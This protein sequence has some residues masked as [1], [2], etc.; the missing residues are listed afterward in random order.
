MIKFETVTYLKHI[1]CDD[2]GSGSIVKC[3]IPDNITNIAVACKIA[4]NKNIEL[5]FPNNLTEID[6][7]GFAHC[8][9][10]EKVIFGN[11][12][13]LQISD[14]AFC[15]CKNIKSIEFG[16]GLEYI[17][18]D[19][20]WQC[21]N[22]KSITFREECIPEF[23]YHCFAECESLE[24]FIF[25]KIVKSINN[26]IFYG[27]SKLT[28]V[29]LPEKINESDEMHIPGYMFGECTSL[30]HIVIPEGY[31]WMDEGAFYR[32]ENLKSII[33][34]KSLIECADDTFEGCKSLNRLRLPPEFKFY[35]N[36]SDYF[37]GCSTSLVLEVAKDSD[38]MKYAIA[39]N[40]AYEVYD[41]F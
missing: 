18:I 6:M 16:A 41:K 26:N 11:S 29:V 36:E 21:K 1:E 40:I 39:H 32:C 25:P 28:S 9:I 31:G 33:F 4:S 22:I 20:F 35:Y 14:D 7:G 19:A 10:I 5:I 15:Q 37:E 13:H 17:G 27:C 2:P 30:E 23:D 12:D 8:N 38:A 24:S 3:M 34:P